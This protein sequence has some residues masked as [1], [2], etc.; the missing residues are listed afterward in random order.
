[1]CNMKNQFSFG[2][3]ISGCC[4]CTVVT[5]MDQSGRKEKKRLSGITDLC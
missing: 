5:D 1:M 2:I 4:D 3:D